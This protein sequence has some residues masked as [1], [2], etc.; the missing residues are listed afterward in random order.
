VYA[1]QPERGTTADLSRLYYKAK[2]AKS[3]GA[4]WDNYGD[5]AGTGPVHYSYLLWTW[6]TLPNG[7]RNAGGGQ[8]RAI[9][10]SG[11]E[12]RACNVSPVLLPMYKAGK[13]KP[14]GQAK[15]YYGQARNAASTIYGWFMTA[16]RYTNGK[17][18]YVVK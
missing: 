2:Q 3:S 4:K 15:W 13:S 16:W 5:Q 9:M 11:Q 1:N 6:P 17:W 8:I 12:I 10:E 14:S 18:H 7:A